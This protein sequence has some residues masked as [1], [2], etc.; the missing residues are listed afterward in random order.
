MWLP[1]VIF[2]VS[3]LNGWLLCL[4]VRL[5]STSLSFRFSTNTFKLILSPLLASDGVSTFFTATLAITGRSGG[6]KG[7]IFIPDDAREGSRLSTA[8]SFSQPSVN[9]KTFRGFSGRPESTEKR[10]SRLVRFG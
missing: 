6:N 3:L 4:K 9:R 10:F 7:K 5:P 2:I 8:P 1:G